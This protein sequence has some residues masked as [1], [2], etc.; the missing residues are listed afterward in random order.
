M[1]V[2][3]VC[4]SGSDWALNYSG[5]VATMRAMWLPG[6]GGTGSDIGPPVGFIIALPRTVVAVYVSW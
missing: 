6:P 2:Q 1:A 3:P 5:A 4:G